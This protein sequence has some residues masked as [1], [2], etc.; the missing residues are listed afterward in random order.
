MIHSFLKV[1]RQFLF[2]GMQVVEIV[3]RYD[4]DCVPETYRGNVTSYI[5]NSLTNKTCIENI[6]VSL[7]CYDNNLFWFF[8]ALT[9]IFLDN[10]LGT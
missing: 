10:S 7:L 8:M 1:I 5:Q 9:R 6:T 4:Q 3:Y 2:T